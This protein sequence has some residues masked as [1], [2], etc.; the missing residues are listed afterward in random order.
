M[1][2]ARAFDRT[3]DQL[4]IRTWASSPLLTQAGRL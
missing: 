1:K 4:M 3:A 2:A